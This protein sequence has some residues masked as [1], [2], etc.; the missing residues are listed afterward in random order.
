MNN[1]LD[2]INIKNVTLDNFC[3]ISNDNIEKVRHWRNSSEVKKFMFSQNE[4]TQVHQ[5]EFIKKLRIDKSKL[6]FLATLKG[7]PIGSI[8]FYNIDFDKM[9]C[10]WG[11]YLNPNLI[12]A[13]YGLVL[14]Y[15]VA[16]VVFEIL[17]LENL[18]C[19]GFVSNKTA[20]KIHREFGFEEIKNT[21][22]IILM[23][24]RKE[25]WTLKKKSIEYLISKLIS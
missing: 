4:I 7:E 22:N 6:Y 24:L 21:N 10:Y 5:K 12:G 13:S 14:E 2:K 15:T 20:I 9:N 25:V 19:E 11:Y 1:H 8:Y 23:L 18:F 3:N 16:E 17:R